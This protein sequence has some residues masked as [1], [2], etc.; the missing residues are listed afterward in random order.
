MS[1]AR[2]HWVLRFGFRPLHSGVELVAL[3][4]RLQLPHLCGVVGTELHLLVPVALQKCQGQH[5][6]QKCPWLDGYPWVGCLGTKHLARCDLHYR[7]I[8]IYIYMDATQPKSWPVTRVQ[9]RGPNQRSPF[10]GTGAD[11]TAGC[12]G[13]SPPANP[14]VRLW[15]C[16][17]LSID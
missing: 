17:R 10:Q 9:K 1:R 11:S 7:C 4:S 5:P 15:D 13:Q 16:W 2:A 14:F 3:G 12:Y 6:P 8:Y